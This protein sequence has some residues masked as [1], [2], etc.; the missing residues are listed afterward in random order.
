[1]CSNRVS[2]ATILISRVTQIAECY[3]GQYKYFIININN[4]IYMSVLSVT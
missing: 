4:Q 3:L 1:M 2:S